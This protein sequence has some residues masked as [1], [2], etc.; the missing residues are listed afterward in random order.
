MTRDPNNLGRRRVPLPGGGVLTVRP[1]ATTDVDG[2]VALYDGLSD[3]DRYR[4]FFSGFRPP[5]SFFERL[6]NVG[7]RGGFGLVATMGAGGDVAGG[8][9]IVGEASYELLPNG[10][11]ELAITVA[12]DQRGWLGPYLLD[13]LVEVAAARGVRNLEADVLVTN[14]R[15]LALLRSRGYATMGSNDWTTLR[16]VVGTAGRTPVWP[17]GHGATGHSDRPRVLVEVPGG[18]WHAGAEADE[19]GLRVIACS[20]PRGARPRC[21]VL[22][23]RPCPLAANAAPSSC[24]T[25]PTTIDG[26]LCSGRTPTSIRACPCASSA[27]CVVAPG[28]SRGRRRPTGARRSRWMKTRIRA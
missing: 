28:T 14:G 5:R 25:L 18:R 24:P 15:M 23:G 11:G 6:V 26:A 22:A 3:D 16:L 1:V 2:L 8:A 7:E 4:R 20:G 12:A 17:A 10:D 19:A 13:A 21:P 27:G 9:R